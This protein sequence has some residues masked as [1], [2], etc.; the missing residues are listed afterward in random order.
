MGEWII[1]AFINLIGSVAINFGTNLLK[2]GH[3]QRERLSMLS[4]DESNRL[5][6]KPIIYFHTWRVGNA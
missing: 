5:M 3:D 2:L 6:L 4:N 1:G